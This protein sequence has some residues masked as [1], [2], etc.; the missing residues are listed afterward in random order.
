MLKFLFS[1]R[2][3]RPPR[4]RTIRSSPCM[5]TCLQGALRRRLLTRL[6]SKARLLEH[7]VLSA[8]EVRE[9]PVR[10]QNPGIS[11]ASLDETGYH[12]ACEIYQ[13]KG[14]PGIAFVLC[15]SLCVCAQG[16]RL[17]TIDLSC[18]HCYCETPHKLVP[19]GCVVIRDQY[20]THVS[21]LDRCRSRATYTGHR[22]SG[23]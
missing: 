12:G 5:P 14:K 13:D 7:D 21:A 18:T 20:A 22:R 17:E 3:V 11:R 2:S 15:P 6:T 19:C 1:E 16:S 10:A 9:M 23:Q 4:T 8:K